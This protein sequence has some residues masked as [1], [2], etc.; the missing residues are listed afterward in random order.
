MKYILFHMSAGLCFAMLFKFLRQNKEC[1]SFSIASSIVQLKLSLP[2]EFSPVCALVLKQSGSQVQGRA[3][4]KKPIKL[5][6]R[7][8]L[9]LPLNFSMSETAHADHQVLYQS[10]GANLNSCR[11]GEERGR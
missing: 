1:F 6:V 2:P 10:S 8:S 11:I 9:A 4:V 5:K 7:L 3:M